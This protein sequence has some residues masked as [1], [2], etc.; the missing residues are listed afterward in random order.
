MHK[1][2]LIHQRMNSKDFFLTTNVLH[3]FKIQFSTKNL[4]AKFFIKVHRFRLIDQKMYSNGFFR[5]LLVTNLLKI[6]FPA[7][8]LLAKIFIKL[9]RFRLQMHR[10]FTKN[11]I[12]KI[13]SGPWWCYICSKFNFLQKIS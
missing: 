3:L 1:F 8:N 12:Q 7:K 5:P 11:L 13:F 9:R 6:K 2:R 4:L 10:L